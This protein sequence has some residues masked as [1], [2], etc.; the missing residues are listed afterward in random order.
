MQYKLE[1]V[2]KN[3]RYGVFNE[4][5]E[6]IAD[7]KYKSMALD[8]IRALNSQEEFVLKDLSYYKELG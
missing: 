2:N 6:L 4:N 8:H 1:L 7:Y 5:N 3:S